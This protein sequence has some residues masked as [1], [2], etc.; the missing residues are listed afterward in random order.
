MSALFNKDVIV[1]VG[2]FSSGRYIAPLFN[3]LG[4]RCIHVC[5]EE[6]KEH[7]LLKPTFQPLDYAE[8]HVLATESEIDVFI[9]QMQAY[10]V[11]AVISGC[12][13]CVLLGDK[14]AEL[15]NVPHNDNALSWAR[16]NKFIMHDTLRKN[17]LKSARQIITDDI[18]EVHAFH[19]SI[20]GK[21]VIK[22]P[23]SSNTDGVYYC[24]NHEQV[25]V[26]F[27]RLLGERNYFGIVN[28][29]VLVQEYL[30]GKQYLV[31]TLSS[32]GHHYVC[33]VWGEV[34]E[35]DDGPSNDIYADLVSPKDSI[36]ASLADYANSVL[37]VLGI[38]YGAAH[39]EI[40]MTDEGPCLVEVG[41]RM[42][43]GVDFSVLHEVYSLTQLS[44]LPDAMLN[45][46]MFL[47]RIQA[48]SPGTQS[49]RKVY[50]SSD[51]DGEVLSDPDMSLFLDIDSV[52]SVF[53]RPAKGDR[54]EKTDR[55]RNVARPGYLYMIGANADVIGRD[56]A[57]ARINETQIYQKM[58][59]A[60]LA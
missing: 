13:P 50:F 30:G 19:A 54:L 26:A 44:L 31:N 5:N 3:G 11:K 16:R 53:F 34:R 12:E 35:N 47:A 6:T 17:G 45:T 20:D 41:A 43:G 55:T 46:D 1:I 2:G 24:D 28:D 4:Y 48:S 10:R 8:S 23:A 15:L 60:E 56:Y 18:D 27:D 21:I 52:A 58:L 38:R 14:L 40:R 22:P 57:R 49:V 39:F 25:A 37:D 9:A 7:P 42:S 59:N 51:M 33:D 36:Y 32:N 29:K